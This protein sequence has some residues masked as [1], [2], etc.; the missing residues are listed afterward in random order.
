MDQWS[1]TVA[2]EE[3]RQSHLL[4]QMTNFNL[5]TLI[6]LWCHDY[7]AELNLIKS[8]TRMKSHF[9]ILTDVSKI[10]MEELKIY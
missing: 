9:V 4:T 1:Q 7:V 5:F 10:T 2:S 6:S 8:S 3:R